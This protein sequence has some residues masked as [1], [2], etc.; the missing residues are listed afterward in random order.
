MATISKED[1]VHLA[2][3][4]LRHSLS[5]YVVAKC[6]E[7]SYKAAGTSNVSDF[8]SIKN[9]NEYF[10]DY[11]QDSLSSTDITKAKVRKL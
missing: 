10:P 1:L 3:E 11:I 5:I 4:L 9:L 2:N 8:N 7:E 6:H